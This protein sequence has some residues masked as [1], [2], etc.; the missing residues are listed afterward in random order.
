[1]D[2]ENTNRKQLQFNPFVVGGAIFAIALIVLLVFALIK[3][4]RGNEFGEEIKI[5]N[6]TSEYQNLP[7]MRQDL[8]ANNLFEAVMFNSPEGTTVPADGAVV[9]E[10]TAEYDYD[11]Q[12]KLYYG[13]FVVDIPEIKQSYRVQFEW[14]T[15]NNN[16]YTGGYPVVISCL[17]K[18]LV[19]YPEFE[20]KNMVEMDSLWENAYQLDYTFGAETS[21]RVRETISDYLMKTTQS[22]GYNVEIDETTLRRDRTQPDLTYAFDIVLNDRERFKI[23]VRMDEMY[24][25]QYLAIYL[26]SDELKKG[27]VLTDDE[28]GFDAL[29]LWLAGL[30]QDGQLSIEKKSLT[31]ENEY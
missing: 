31:E 18:E 28:N 11:E 12:A 23:V 8:I 6:L 20:C 29:S 14:T 13:N 21:S 10:G 19:I 24:G 17:E 26:S 25:K 2:F 22:Y 4:L 1:M 3:L 27:F 9:R 15:D 7:Q 16:E 5:N 30:S